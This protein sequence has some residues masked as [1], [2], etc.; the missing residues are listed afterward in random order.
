MS[1]TKPA[2]PRQIPAGRLALA[3][4]LTVPLAARCAPPS[5][6]GMGPRPNIIVF[7]ADDLGYYDV[8]FNGNPVIRTPHIDRFAAEGVTLRAAYSGAPVCS[9]AR[10]ALLTGRF[11]AAVGIFDTVLESFGTAPAARRAETMSLS[12]SVRTIANLLQDGGYQTYHAGKW[13]V[14]DD[15]PRAGRQY[16]FDASHDFNTG[17]AWHLVGRARWWLE[18]HRDPDRPFFMYLAPIEPHYPVDERSPPPYRTPYQ[19]PEAEAAGGEIPYRGC[20]RSDAGWSERTAY[21]GNVSQ[22]DDAFGWLLD[23]LDENGLR[24]NTFILF[25]S[26][27]GP[28]P[29]PGAW[30]SAGPYSGCKSMLYE[31]GIRVPGAVQW[32][33]R[34]SDGLVS[35]E[36]IHAVDLL[37]TLAAVAGVRLE[38]GADLDGVSFLPA[39]QGTALERT[40][41]L[42]WSFWR[43]QARRGAY[44]AGGGM[45]AAV[46]EGDWKL[47]GRLEPLPGDWTVMEYIERARFDG[48]E[49]Y[50]LASDPG[51]S[52]DLAESRPEVVERLEGQMIS[53]RRR[54]LRSSPRWDLEHQRRLAARKS[55][56]AAGGG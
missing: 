31:G 7:L 15:F 47:L 12:R 14:S 48:F 9:P 11:P 39:L 24:E 19:T 2:F 52:R 34:M 22:L 17:L 42:F 4:L 51:E 35:D 41:P 43:G 28:A 20:P 45:Q 29:A 8:G 3:L 37:P 46:R 40:V 30:G 38:E 32:P 55:M 44:A 23:Y 36:P 16:G 56:V 10:A 49:L 27:N 53:I 13:H 50:D 25:T 5:R 26:D 18:R 33:G 6:A 54:N 1:P 21:F